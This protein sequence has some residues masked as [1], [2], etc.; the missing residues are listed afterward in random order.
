MFGIFSWVT[1]AK[2][3]FAG[4]TQYIMHWGIFGGIAAACILLAVFSGVIP[5]IGPYLT[6]LRKD[7]YWVAFGCG[8]IMLGMFISGRD[9]A[10]RYA[11]KQAV[12]STTVDTAVDK[13][14]M[15]AARHQKDRWDNP[16]Y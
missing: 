10:H 3:A 4:A 5:V 13:T 14:T 12:V 11:A 2:L 6:A 16:N 1:S 9:A 15:P 7:L 8:L